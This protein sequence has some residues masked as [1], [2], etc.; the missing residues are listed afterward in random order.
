MIPRPH[1]EREYITPPSKPCPVTSYARTFRAHYAEMD[2]EYRRCKA[3]PRQFNLGDCWLW[4]A[5]D[6][7]WVFNL[8]T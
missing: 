3:V 6:R 2:E 4:K 8:G 7:P 5:E 1:P